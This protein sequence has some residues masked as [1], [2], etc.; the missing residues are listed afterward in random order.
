MEK[1]SHVC[2]LHENFIALALQSS[3]HQLWAALC[4]GHL[5]QHCLQQDGRMDMAVVQLAFIFLSSKARM[6][7]PTAMHLN[8][9]KLPNSCFLCCKLKS[10]IIS[11]FRQVVQEEEIPAL[12]WGI[13][14][15]G[16]YEEENMAELFTRIWSPEIKSVQRAERRTC[17]ILIGMVWI[18]RNTA[19]ALQKPT[20]HCHINL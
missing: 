18:M 5:E 12:A 20:C 11:K 13:L 7:S 9:S 1:S 10:Q 19:T 4:R 16:Y 17:T 3:K 15:W 6:V 2:Q 14:M 8:G